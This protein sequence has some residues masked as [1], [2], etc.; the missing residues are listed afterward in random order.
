[1]IKSSAHT[2]NFAN[3]GKQSTL[4]DFL[5]EYD[6]VKWFFVDYIWNNKLEWST[7][8]TDIQN[9]KLDIPNFI[10]TKDIPITT[11][12][13]ARAVKLASGEALAVT[14]SQTE[15]R[16]KQLFILDK[17]IQSGD[18]DAYTKLQSKIDEKPLIQPTKTNTAL[19]A[20]L[21]S[22]CCEFIPNKSKEFDGFLK[23]HAI[24]KIYGHIYIPIKN[25][26]HSNK[27]KNNGYEL[28]T[29]WQIGVDGK[30]K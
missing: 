5:S 21:D 2:T 15:K 22:N 6:R 10:S 17:L 28:I 9:N 3:I 18:I 25:T 26:K 20:N 19:Y 27:L 1:M 14:K 4:T 13:S 23:I 11:D 12:L 29:S 30:K 8:T 24:G 16:R 7:H